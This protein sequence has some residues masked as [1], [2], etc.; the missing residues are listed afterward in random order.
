M[1]KVNAALAYL[2]KGMT[3]ERETHVAEV[4]N[5]EYV[6]AAREILSREEV[7]AAE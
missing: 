3:E 6:K 2:K 7:P 4:L 5:M 1:T